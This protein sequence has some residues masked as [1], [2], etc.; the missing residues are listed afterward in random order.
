M[1]SQHAPLMK[2]AEY[3]IVIGKLSVAVRTN[4]NQIF[5]TSYGLL[6]HKAT[7]QKKIYI[8]TDDTTNETTSGTK[9]DTNNNKMASHKG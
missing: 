1:C 6:N 8:Y 3:R 4:I 5:D 2:V 7:K 9:D